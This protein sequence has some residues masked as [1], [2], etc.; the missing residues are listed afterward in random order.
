[1]E[2]TPLHYNRTN[3]KTTIKRLKNCYVCPYR[4]N[5]DLSHCHKCPPQQLMKELNVIIDF[6]FDN[7]KQAKNEQRLEREKEYKCKNL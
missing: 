6:Y 1:M 3:F 5:N 7:L 2:I 4:Q